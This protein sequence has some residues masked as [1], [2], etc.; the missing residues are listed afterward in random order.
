M[1]KT[2]T[3]IIRGDNRILIGMGVKRKYPET[4]FMLL[5]YMQL[6]PKHF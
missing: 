5:K 3:W 4:L 1:K 6:L 2:G